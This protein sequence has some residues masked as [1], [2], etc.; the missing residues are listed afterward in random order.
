MSNDLLVKRL[1]EA[2]QL[3]SKKYGDAGYDFFVDWIEPIFADIRESTQQLVAE[4]WAAR[5][6]FAL[7][8]AGYS[9]RGDWGAL[10]A[11]K[12]HTGIAV[13][14]PPGYWMLL[15]PRSGASVKYGLSVLAGVIDNGYRGEIVGVVTCAQ[16]CEVKRGDRLFQGVL[17]PYVE[18][19]VLEVA[20]LPESDRG[21]A[22][23]GASGR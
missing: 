13:A 22:G 9:T 18:R 20:Q 4:E 6:S 10:V 2:S 1:T 23:F 19:A 11:F 12:V 17:L 8:P 15:K 3:P 14:L 5:T 16:P 21:E 7:V